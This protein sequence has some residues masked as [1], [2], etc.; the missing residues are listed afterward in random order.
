MTNYLVVGPTGFVGSYIARELILSNSNYALLTRNPSACIS[1]FRNL[2]PSSVFFF[3]I[4]KPS[5]SQFSKYFFDKP[6]FVIITA[7]IGLFASKSCLAAFISVF[8]RDTHFLFMS[9][10]GIYTSL[11]SPNTLPRHQAESNIRSIHQLKYTIIRPNM[12]YGSINDRNISNLFSLP[13]LSFC[14]IALQ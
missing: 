11:P 5:S 8:P 1:S 9:S 10:S 4:L 6:C 2:N 14:F 13:F 12:I 7:G 3:D